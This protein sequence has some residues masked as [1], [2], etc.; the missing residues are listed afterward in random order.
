MNVE[1]NETGNTKSILICV[2]I[3]ALACVFA[4]VLPP[5]RG[6]LRFDKRSRQIFPYKSQGKRESAKA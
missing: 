4:I 2:V 3:A 5:T 1:M 6:P